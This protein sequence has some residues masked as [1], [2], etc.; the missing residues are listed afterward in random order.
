M[1]M[2]RTHILLFGSATL[3]TSL[4][5]EMFAIGVRNEKKY[6]YIIYNIVYPNNPTELLPT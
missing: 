5:L 6:I 2:I 1:Y 4:D 3:D